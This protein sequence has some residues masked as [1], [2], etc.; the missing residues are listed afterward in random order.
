MT[1][2]APKWPTT[3][4][5]LL[6]I[7]KK[8]KEEA[9]ESWGKG[10]Q[11]QTWKWLMNHGFVSYWKPKGEKLLSCCLCRVCDTVMC[12]W[13]L[14]FV[15]KSQHKNEN[16]RSELP[17]FIFFLVVKSCLFGIEL[18]ELNSGTRG[19]S[20]VA[21]STLHSFWA[22]FAVSADWLTHRTVEK[23]SSDISMFVP[24]DRFT[25]VWEGT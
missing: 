16:S 10:K 8:S 12:I 17:L 13:V 7:F 19:V 6:N 11:R 14:V 24:F 9:L 22:K 5:L 20:L 25:P 3:F 1:T 21:D 2:L 15:C 23:R 18:N 4:F